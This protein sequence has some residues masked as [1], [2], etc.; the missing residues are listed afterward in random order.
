[1]GDSIRL[2]QPAFD[3]IGDAEAVERSEEAPTRALAVLR[4]VGEAPI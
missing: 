3:S 1:M 2:G 4:H